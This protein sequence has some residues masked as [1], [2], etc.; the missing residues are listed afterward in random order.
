MK[1]FLAGLIL[2]QTLLGAGALAPERE[3]R[4][5]IRALA[6]SGPSIELSDA[7]NA[8][9]SFHFEQGDYPG[10]ERQSR[11][12]LSVERSIDP[13][14]P[15]EIARRLANVGAALVA[16]D[17]RREAAPFVEEALKI[18]QR[19]NAPFETAFAL[20]TLGDIALHAHRP[21]EAAVL[22]QRALTLWSNC[23]AQYA[24][25]MANLALAQSTLNQSPQALETWEHAVVIAQDALP[26]GR[27]HGAIL[28][29]YARA[30]ER[31]GMRVQSSFAH[32][33]GKAML[34]SL[35]RAAGRTIDVSDFSPR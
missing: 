5:R 14:R 4:A 12:A 10:A 16:Q 31:A 15:L 8:L 9:G 7:L 32:A 33:A 25:G 26:P 19:T 6:A 17:R 21:K 35:P 34:E 28:E 20:N 3:Y 13:L 23:P 2:I 29:G 27:I 18:L 11:S 1:L 24:Q 30:L 22:F